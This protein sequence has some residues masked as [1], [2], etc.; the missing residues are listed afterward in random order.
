MGFGIGIGIGLR[1]EISELRCIIPNIITYGCTVPFIFLFAYIGFSF[2]KHCALK[3]LSMYH[4]HLLLFIHFRNT[5]IMSHY[6]AY[7]TFHLGRC[8]GLVANDST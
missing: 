3:V 6:I 5:S 8:N 7:L 2:D 4:L 1:L